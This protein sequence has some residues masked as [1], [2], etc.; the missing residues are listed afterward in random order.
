[1]KIKSKKIVNPRFG[2]LDVQ[3]ELI[4]LEVDDFDEVDEKISSFMISSSVLTLKAKGNYIAIN[5]APTL[6][7]IN[8]VE[9]YLNEKNISKSRIANF[10]DLLDSIQTLDI[11]DYWINEDVRFLVYTYIKFCVCILTAEKTNLYLHQD[12]KEASE[13]FLKQ[14]KTANLLT[15]ILES[16]QIHYS[17]Y[18]V[19]NRAK[20]LLILGLDPKNQFTAEEIKKIGREWMKLTHPDAEFG[21]HE[22]FKK[23]NEAVS[24]LK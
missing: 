17:D 15:N 7:S 12:C 19:N 14:R 16:S 18:V 3:G 8:D 22:I 4:K 6:Q 20:Y 21:D 11:K 2:P 24:Y 9:F 1:M 5:L 13:F 10:S 23:V